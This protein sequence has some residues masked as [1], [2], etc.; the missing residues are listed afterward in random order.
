MS[1]QGT[2]RVQ[3]QL[4]VVEAIATDY[5]LTD[6]EKIEQIIESINNYYK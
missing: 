4:I 3:K 6:S 2:L 1:A 5:V